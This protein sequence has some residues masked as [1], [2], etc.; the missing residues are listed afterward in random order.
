M[1]RL[2]GECGGLLSEKEAS[3]RPQRCFRIDIPSKGAFFMGRM[4]KNVY[5]LKMGC[6]FAS[7]IML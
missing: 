5:P 7:G 3:H 1:L 4:R 6:L 2:S